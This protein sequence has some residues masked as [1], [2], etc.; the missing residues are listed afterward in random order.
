MARKRRKI[1]LDMNF[2]SNFIDELCHKY[3]EMPVAATMTEW[4]KWKKE[5]KE[6]HP[7]LYVLLKKIPSWFSYKIYWV[8]NT[9]YQLRSKYIKKQHYIKIDVERFIIP[10]LQAYHWYDS[11][12]RIL[13]GNFQILVDFIEGEE[14]GE[15]IDWNSDPEHQKAWA[16]ITALYDWWTKERPEH[17]EGYPD[18]K[19]YGLEENEFMDGEDSPNRRR[20]LKALDELHQQEEEWEVEDTEMLIR[21]ITIRKWMWT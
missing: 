9:H 13:Y 15:R 1:N 2:I 11:D 20:Y 6:K 21:L 3:L 8:T 12:T 17:D 7:V 19:D 10:G 16:E 18:T 5:Q 4:S 14:P